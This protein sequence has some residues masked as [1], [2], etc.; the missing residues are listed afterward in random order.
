MDGGGGGGGW[1][2]GGGGQGEILFSFNVNINSPL[3]PAI[4]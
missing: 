4:L 2:V 3:S 1:M